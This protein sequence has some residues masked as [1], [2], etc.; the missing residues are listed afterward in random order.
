M[1]K[2]AFKALREHTGLSH[3]VIADTLGVNE[4]SVKCWEDPR[5]SDPPE[6]ACRIVREARDLQLA[7]ADRAL[8][9]AEAAAVPSVRLSCC[10]TQAEFDICGSDEGDYRRAKANTRVVADALE[11]MGYDIEYH[12]PADDGW[13]ETSPNRERR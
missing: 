3:A 12:Y 6:D 2:A 7:M 11:M 5:Y 10:R 4:R 1:N 8:V 13:T 9:K